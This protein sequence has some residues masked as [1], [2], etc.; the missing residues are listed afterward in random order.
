MFDKNISLD[1][2]QPAD[3]DCLS[4]KSSDVFLSIL[5]RVQAYMYN[6]SPV[7]SLCVVC[8]PALYNSMHVSMHV[9]ACF[10][11]YLAC[12]Q[13][14]IM[15]R[16]TYVKPESSFDKQTVV[17]YCLSPTCCCCCFCLYQRI[18]SSGECSRHRHGLEDK[19]F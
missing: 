6:N 8:C 3:R 11:Q 5:G 1:S 4:R 10:V 12:S 19:V 13:A 2:R 7:T 9:C 18:L 16:A 14:T 17:N 15:I